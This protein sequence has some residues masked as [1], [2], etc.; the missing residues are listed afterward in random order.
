MLACIADEQKRNS[1]T[2]ERMLLLL[3]VEMGG[4]SKNLSS[5][6]SSP[7]SSSPF[8]FAVPEGAHTHQVLHSHT[9]NSSPADLGKAD[10]T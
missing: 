1:L 9:L 10:V 3:R 5:S 6:P 7:F 8:S 2:S 4:I